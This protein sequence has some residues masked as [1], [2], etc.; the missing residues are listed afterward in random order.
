[1]TVKCIIGEIE[2]E[3]KRWIQSRE[4]GNESGHFHRWS[5]NH[6]PEK[7]L[8]FTFAQK[9][10]IWRAVRTRFFKPERSIAI[11]RLRLML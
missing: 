11:C 9:L 5:H 10:G 6:A 3:T 8:R 4:V 7:K 2:T 1:M